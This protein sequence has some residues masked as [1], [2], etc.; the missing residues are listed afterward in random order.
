[1]ESFSQAF[2]GLPPKDLCFLEVGQL[3]THTLSLEV[4]L[5]QQCGAMEIDGSNSTF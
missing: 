3:R 2:T 1:M 5:V 4:D